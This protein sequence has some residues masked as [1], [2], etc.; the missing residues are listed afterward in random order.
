MR[1]A[2]VLSVKVEEKE[3]EKEGEGEK[4][5]RGRFAIYLSWWLAGRLTPVEPVKQQANLLAP[6]R[7]AS[8]EWEVAGISS[9]I[10]SE[11]SEL[12]C[13]MLECWLL[14]GPLASR[15]FDGVSRGVGTVKGSRYA[16]R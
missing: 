13:F 16:S 9:G 6:R 1:Y 3:G 5:G 7:L 14:E 12:G 11:R 15:R 2:E 4:A 8:F 10:A